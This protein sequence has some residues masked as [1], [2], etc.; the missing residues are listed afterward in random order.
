MSSRDVDHPS[1]RESEGPTGPDRRFFEAPGD[2]TA[3]LLAMVRNFLGGSPT[4]V[5]LADSEGTLIWLNE[6]C[7]KLFRIPRDSHVVGRYNLF[8]DDV[9]RE[10]GVLPVLRRV[11][12]AGVTARFDLEYDTS[13]VQGFRVSRPRRLYVHT[14]VLPLKDRAGRIS[15]A[16]IQ[17]VDLTGRK[18][19]EEALRLSETRLLQAQAIA[20]VG[21]WELDLATGTMWGSE[22][23]F[24]VYGAERV[25]PTV[26][27]SQVESHVVEADRPRMAAAL[28]DLVERGGRYDLEFRIRRPNDGVLCTFH[29]VAE[30]VRDDSGAPVKVIGVVQDVTEQR[31]VE[32]RLRL[33]EYS[34]DHAD[35]SI[36]WTDGGGWIIWVS[37]STCRNLGYSSDD[38]LGM[39]LFEIEDTLTPREWEER[40]S[41]I[42]GGDVLTFET[43]HVKADGTRLDVEVSVNHM[44]YGGEEYSCMF[45]RDIAARKAAQEALRVSEEQLRQSQKMEA[46]GLLAGGIAHDFNN[47]LTAIM[48]YVDLLLEQAGDDES[49]RP[50]LEEIRGAATRAASLTSQILAFSRRQTLLPRLASLNEVVSGVAPLL[51][52]ALGE[53]IDLVTEQDPDLGLVHVDVHQ[54]EQVLMNLAVNAHDAM[55]SGG[56]LTLRTA[57]VEVDA[58][59]ARTL[60]G[61]AP[62]SY[63]TLSACD[64]G[65][66]MDEDTMA[67]VYEPFFTTKEPGRGTGLGL[68]T[69]YG[70][71]RQSGGDMAVQSREGEGTCFTVY[72]PRARESA[73]TESAREVEAP[74]VDAAGGTVLV[75]ED[76]A[77]LRRLAVR[78]LTG[79]GCQTLVAGSGP[80]A[81]EIL[82]HSEK[83]PDVLLTDLA[84]PGGLQGHEL[85]AQVRS[86]LPGIPVVYMSGY[87]SDSL[88]GTDGVEQG[89]DFLQKPFT[90]DALATA[91]GRALDARRHPGMTTA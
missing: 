38:L 64:T 26:P 68:S 66:G 34:V 3:G 72:L 37:E 11:F 78:V 6:A 1:T 80:E 32:E 65:H 49:L 8:R 43:T 51:R 62:G 19:A 73:Q 67:R 91:V 12:K 10:R 63:V 4:A 50:D 42:R 59:S 77:A 69:V 88:T 15:H 36:F 25:S 85:A 27:L 48:G 60:P 7:R 14:T 40:W 90:P 70:I 58:A 41:R 28:S 16:I 79:L 17:H 39:S 24:R 45:A 20:K 47:L 89:T 53:A 29:S 22:E 46:V 13:K 44:E 71:V 84:L 57:N 33:T 76:E 52:R 31:R 18:M 54:F 9:L 30:L 87:A 21:N 81:L 55:P 5:W 35:E 56:R 2:D 61:L 23:A 83:S 74:A 86:L 75:V 82:R